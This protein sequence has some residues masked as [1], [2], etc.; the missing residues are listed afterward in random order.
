MKTLGEIQ[1]EYKNSIEKT[2]NDCGV[3]WAFSDSQLEEGMKK[4]GV[5][6]RSLLL[7]IGMGGFMV[8]ANKERYLKEMEANYSQFVGDIDQ[9]NQ[10]EAYIL[11]E[12]NNHEAFYTGSIESTIE[13][14]I[15]DYT[16]EEVEKVYKK[17]K[18]Q[19]YIKK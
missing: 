8:K 4:V 13:S 5:A 18:A 17:F 6:N 10:R 16:K 11:Y 19:K 15:G 9:N 12:L 14:L 1:T 2:M 7:S 3:F